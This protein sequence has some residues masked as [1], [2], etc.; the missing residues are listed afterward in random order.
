MAVGVG[1][2]LRPFAATAAVLVVVAGLAAAGLATAGPGTPWPPGVAPIAAFVSHDRGLAFVRPVPVHFQTP[3]AFDAEVARETTPTTP[4]TLAAV[5]RYAAELRALGLLDG[6]VDVVAAETAA[7]AGGAVLGYY[8][9]TTKALYLRGRSLTPAVQVTLAHELTH[10]LQDQ[11]FGLN[12]LDRRAKT[13]E[14]TFGL[15]ALEE[16]DAVVDQDDYQSSLPVAEQRRATDQP[17]TPGPTTGPTASALTVPVLTATASVPYV[18]GPDLV[19]AVFAA[20][21]DTVADG[22]AAIDRA[23]R[24]P[25]ATELDVLD[26]VDYLRHLGSRTLPAPARPAGSHRQGGRQTFGAFTLYLTLAARLPARQALSAAG[27]WGGGSMVQYRTP[28][29]RSCLTADVVG[30]TPAGTAALAGA[31]ARWAAAM[32]AGQA[33]VAT[34][35]GGAVPG[36]PV[37]GGPVPGGAGSGPLVRLTACDPGR[38]AKAGPGTLDAALTLAD[39][40]DQNEVDALYDGASPTVAGCVGDRALSDK[41]LLRAETTVNGTYGTPPAAATRTVTGRLHRLIRGCRR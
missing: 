10:A 31:L 28:T 32:P 13:E 16:G 4:A 20:H 35:P 34:V 11:H 12:R 7:D 6:S 23:Y 8:T 41:A 40:R 30:R 33:T 25:P 36:G 14:E 38:A 21:A 37:P 18:L 9:P 3:R 17:T 27:R 22:N 29:G 2:R 5:R 15:T 24:D 19:G 26:P 1:S 39:Q